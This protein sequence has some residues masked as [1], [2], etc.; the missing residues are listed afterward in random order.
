MC[1]NWCPIDKF[2]AKKTL[3]YSQAKSCLWQTPLGLQRKYLIYKVES[4]CSS[5][6]KYRILLRACTVVHLRTL[7][8]I[9]CLGSAQETAREKH[10]SSH[11][12]PSPI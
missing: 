9:I 12:N 4:L 10:R 5:T 7:H 2:I 6:H 1:K 3:I 11:L 8:I